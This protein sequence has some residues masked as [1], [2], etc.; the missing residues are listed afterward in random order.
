[1][2]AISRHKDAVD[3]IPHGHPDKPARLNNLGKSF[4]TV[5]S[6]SGRGKVQHRAANVSCISLILPMKRRL[7]FV[8]TSCHVT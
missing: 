3:F 6:A 5:S 8:S 1:M 4:V 7:G 2:D